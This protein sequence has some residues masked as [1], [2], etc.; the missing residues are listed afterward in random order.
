ML[1][2]E[3]ENRALKLLIGA[4]GIYLCYFLSSI[5][6]ERMYELCLI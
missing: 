5:L 2:K 6:S 3:S 1:Y 4:S